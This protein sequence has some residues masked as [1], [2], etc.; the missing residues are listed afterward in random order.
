MCGGRMG[1][2]SGSNP[3]APDEGQDHPSSQCTCQISRLC[4]K[5]TFYSPTSPRTFE[6]A[7]YGFYN[8][9]CEYEQVT[10]SKSFTLPL[11]PFLKGNGAT[12]TIC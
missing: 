5:L 3:S 7:R 12:V 9:L 11:P 4:L 8:Y 1:G 10:L 2:G 6:W